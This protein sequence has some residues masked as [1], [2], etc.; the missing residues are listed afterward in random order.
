MLDGVVEQ[1]KEQTQP[2]NGAV[3]VYLYN[4]GSRTILQTQTHSRC[5]PYYI[6][7]PMTNFRSNGNQESGMGERQRAM[8]VTPRIL[9]CCKRH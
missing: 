4:N 7:V 8:L 9:A 1:A 5:I 2:Y 6:P 3:A